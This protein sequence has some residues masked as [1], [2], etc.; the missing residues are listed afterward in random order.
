MKSTEGLESH[1]AD[2]LSAVSV[3]PHRDGAEG[4]ITVQFDYSIKNLSIFRR[5]Y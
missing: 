1:E 3:V 2:T 5:M 4:N